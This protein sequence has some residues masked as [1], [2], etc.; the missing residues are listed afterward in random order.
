M[1]NPTFYKRNILKSFFILSLTFTVLISC[2]SE[3]K[4]DQQITTEEKK[5]N[6]IEI[7]TEGM[8]FQSVDTILSGWNTFKY[9]NKSTQAHFFL[10]DKYP[11]GKTI[12]NTIEEV[13]PP[14]D[15]G[16]EFIMEGKIEEAMAEFG[17]LPEW[18]SKIV[19]TGGSGLVSPNQTSITT[20]KLDPGLYIM[21]CYVKMADGK[22]HTSMGMAKEIHVLEEDSRHLPPSADIY[23][24]IS[25][26]DG[27]NYNE[28]INKGIHTF[29][30]HYKDQIVHE[31]FV[32]HD[33]NLVKLDHNADL[34]K[35]EDWMNWATPTGLM[36]PIPEGVTFLGGTNDAPAGSTQYFKAHLDPGDYAFISE[37]PNTSKKGMLKTFTILD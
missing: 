17:K 2:K 12:Q 4:Q 28:K 10:L 1:T 37:V 18:F 33:V 5:D 35:L 20:V 23:I 27:I 29:S 36:D 15:K 16:M 32:G 25:S 19:F 11:E 24:T 3:K 6:F 34:K 22:F 26:T 31:N 13:G 8:D 7:I 30:V 9:M 21:E 14:F